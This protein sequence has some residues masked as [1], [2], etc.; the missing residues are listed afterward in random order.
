MEKQLENGNDT[1]TLNIKV[2]VN[3]LHSE[4]LKKLLLVLS[5][6]TLGE[7]FIRFLQRHTLNELNNKEDY[8][9][10]WMYKVI[11]NVSKQL[12][13][14]HKNVASDVI[15]FLVEDNSWVEKLK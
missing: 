13:A 2:K 1:L 11:K 9:E 3:K 7:Y 12:E 6:E 8:L 15:D 14:T 4:Y 5:D 10:N